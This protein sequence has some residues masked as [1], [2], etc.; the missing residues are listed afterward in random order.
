M[1]HQRGKEK[2][3]KKISANS[4]PLKT[5][6]THTNQRTLKSL[7]SLDMCTLCLQPGLNSAFAVALLAV[8]LLYIQVT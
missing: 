7:T 8:T 5:L 3:Q 1:K 4:T 6:V 2:E